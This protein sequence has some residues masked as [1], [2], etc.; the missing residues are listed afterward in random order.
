MYERDNV[1][2][3]IL[4]SINSVYIGNNMDTIPWS[5]FTERLV[6]LDEGKTYETVSVS[7]ASQIVDDMLAEPNSQLAKIPYAKDTIHKV[8]KNLNYQ[9]T[10]EMKLWYYANT[11]NDEKVQWILHVHPNMDINLASSTNSTPLDTAIMLYCHYFGKAKYADKQQR[12]FN[13]VKALV[14][15]PRIHVPTNANSAFM[16]ACGKGQTDLMKLIMSSPHTISD[17]FDRQVFFSGRQLAVEYLIAIRDD[18]ENH[19]PR[20]EIVNY[21]QKLVD[22][23]TFSDLPYFLE[24]YLAHPIATRQKLRDKFMLD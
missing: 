14:S 3:K 20:Q 7:E 23:D 8:V 19:I 5:L 9:A 10:S 17:E 22:N 1:K 2:L 16:M 18:V 11:G 12:Y 13:V 24:A 6:S 21:R 4:T 15:D